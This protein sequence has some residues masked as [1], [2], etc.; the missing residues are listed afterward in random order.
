M[1]GRGGSTEWESGHG[2]VRLLML[3]EEIWMRGSTS[4]VKL[5]CGS[6]LLLLL[7]DVCLLHDH[8]LICEGHLGVWIEV[9]LL[10]GDS[11]RGVLL[12]KGVKAGIKGGCV[13]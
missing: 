3:G 5:E 2:G 12:E 1:G 9:G 10:L 4:H 7:E 13:W 8:V 6:G 11:E